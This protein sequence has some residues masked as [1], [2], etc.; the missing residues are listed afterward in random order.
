MDQR[1]SQERGWLRL[2]EIDQSES[3]TG[4]G[5]ANDG[6]PIPAVQQGIRAKDRRGHHERR[7]RRVP[8]PAQNSPHES[9]EEQLFNRR[10]EGKKVENLDGKGRTITH[11]TMP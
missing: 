7:G 2:P 10:V 9:P 8:P 4:G 6:P 3:Q 1:H 11:K 5:R